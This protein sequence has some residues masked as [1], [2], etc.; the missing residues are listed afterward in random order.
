MKHVARATSA[1]PTYFEPAIVQIGELQKTLVDGGVFIN[2]PTMSAYASA[3][4]L[5][6]EEDDFLV[7]SLGTGELIRPIN[8]SEAKDWGKAGWLLPLL[9]CIFDGVADAAD[10]QMKALL[11]KGY[12]R[13]QTTLTTAS[14]DMD[15]VTNGNIENLKVEARTLIRTHR[16]EL[17]DICQLLES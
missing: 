6:L 3:R 17:Q 7:L 8:Y 14:D 4:K 10:Y 1:A 11:G 12:H 13:L 2:S 16:V 15:N 9:N 5:F